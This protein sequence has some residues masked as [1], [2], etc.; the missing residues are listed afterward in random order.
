MNTTVF[1]LFCRFAVKLTFSLDCKQYLFLFCRTNAQMNNE[2]MKV[3]SACRT[4]LFE[5]VLP[6]TNPLCAIQ[7]PRLV[8]YIIKNYQVSGRNGIYSDTFQRFIK[9]STC[10]SVC[11]IMLNM[12]TR[13][14]QSPGGAS[15]SSEILNEFSRQ[16]IGREELMTYSL[17]K[18][19]IEIRRSQSGQKIP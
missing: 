16:F 8:F 18:I 11:G 4:H 10:S 13:M 17:V 9:S 5:L 19:V 15:A 3:G 14:R 2:R 7:Q 12:L 1:S 6:N